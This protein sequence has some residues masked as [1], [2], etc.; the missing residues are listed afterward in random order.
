M[1]DDAWK[2]DGA[3]DFWIPFLAEAELDNAI[4]AGLLQRLAWQESDHFAEDVIRGKRASPA[5]ALGIMQMMP[6][7]F[8]LVTAPTPFSDAAVER[9]ISKAAWHLR[10]LFDQVHSWELAVGA[11]NCGLGAISRYKGLPPFPET[12]KYVAVVLQ[13]F[14]QL[15]SPP[16]QPA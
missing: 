16:S 3:G 8:P 2:H 15:Y 6:R 10:W 12:Q 4:P 11:Y 7:Y 1:T 9:Q 5:G 13:D 14:P